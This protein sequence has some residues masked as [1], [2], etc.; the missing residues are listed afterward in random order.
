MTKAPV[1]KASPKPAT[2]EL[3]NLSKADLI[4][5]LLGQLAKEDADARV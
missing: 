1:V 4:K 5:M 3:A 2:T